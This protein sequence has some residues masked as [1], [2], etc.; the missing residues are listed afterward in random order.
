MASPA[1]ADASAATAHCPGPP[2][3]V[4]ANSKSA[5]AAPAAI[6]SMAIMMA[7]VWAKLAGPA[8]A[9]PQARTVAARMRLI[10]AKLGDSDSKPENGFEAGSSYMFDVPVVVP[11]D[12]SHLRK[13]ARQ[14]LAASS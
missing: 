4:R 11:Q 6:L 8:H 10:D 7:P 5:G 9:T 14:L 13:G 2:W 12:M 1:A 3:P